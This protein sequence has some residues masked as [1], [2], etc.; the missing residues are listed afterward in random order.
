MTEPRDYDVGYG[1]PPED[2]RWK[3]GTSGNPR[4]RSKGSKGLRRIVDEE[5]RALQTI[6]IDGKEVTAPRLVQTIRTLTIRAGAGDI[7]AQ[8][9]LVPLIVQ[10]LG[11]EDRGTGAARLSPIDQAILDELLNEA[12]GLQGH[13][14]DGETG[15]G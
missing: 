1:K 14:G 13:S 3:K 15:D 9:T 5:T 6:R 2:T 4:G 8:Q 10:T 7:K 11:Y 12:E